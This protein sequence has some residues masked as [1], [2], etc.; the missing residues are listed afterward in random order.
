MLYRLDET[1]TQFSILQEAQ[2]HCKIRKSNETL[3]TA[4]QEVLNC[5]NSAQLYFKEGLHLFDS[6]LEEKN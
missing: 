5:I 3:L 1:S 4:L 2:E 6:D